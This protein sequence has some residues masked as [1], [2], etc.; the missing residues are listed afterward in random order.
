MD[1]SSVPAFHDHLPARTLA[2]FGAVAYGLA[3]FTTSNLE[4][5]VVELACYPCYRPV[6]GMRPTD[7]TSLVLQNR[8]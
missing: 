8:F 1:L 4:L 7:V 6:I 5:P 3:G 2:R